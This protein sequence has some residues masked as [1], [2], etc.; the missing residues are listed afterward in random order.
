MAKKTNTDNKEKAVVPEK[1][2]KTEKKEINFEFSPYI[3]LQV[4][5]FDKAVEFYKNILGFDLIKKYQK[6]AHFKKGKT[7]FFVEKQKP[8]RVILEF[9][10]EDFDEAKALLEKQ[11]CT[12]VMLY[13]KKSALFLDPYGVTFHIFQELE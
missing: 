11:G 8:G 2:D 12:I 13:N 10:V 6:E 4:R 9:K 5:D 1:N 3:A 7:N